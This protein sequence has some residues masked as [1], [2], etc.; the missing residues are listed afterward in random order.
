MGFTGE[1]II[2]G[3]ISVYIFT[4]LCGD[5]FEGVW[6]VAFVGVFPCIF[7]NFNVGLK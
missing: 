6:G 1:E 3:G 4:D 5:V 2:L 7:V